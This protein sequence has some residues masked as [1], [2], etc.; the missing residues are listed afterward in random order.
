MEKRNY[1]SVERGIHARNTLRSDTVAASPSGG[2]PL[3]SYMK[4]H[5]KERPVPEWK[6]LKEMREGPITLLDPE[7]IVSPAIKVGIRIFSGISHADIH[8]RNLRLIQEAL[9]SQHEVIDGFTTT[10]Y[11]FVDRQEAARIAYAAGQTKKD[12]ASL[13]SYHIR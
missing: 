11:R 10:N 3:I 2:K 13:K 8:I 1:A 12:E 7:K 6:V 9:C 4:K 5:F